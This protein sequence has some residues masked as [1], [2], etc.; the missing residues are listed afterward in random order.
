M[1]K[2]ETYDEF[3]KKFEPKKTTD[4]CYTPAPIMDV[5]NRWAAKEFDLDPAKYIRPF[6]PGGDYQA[7]DYTDRVV[8]DNPPFSILAEIIKWYNERNIKFVLFAPVLTCTQLLRYGLSAYTIKTQIVYENGAQVRTCFLTNI[9]DQNYIVF[10]RELENAIKEVKGNKTKPKLVVPGLLRTIEV[11]TNEIEEPQY[12]AGMK[13]IRKYNG[14]DV[15]GGGFI[16]EE[17]GQDA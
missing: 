3:V 6:Y 13:F 10:S 11:M 12:L 2:N 1:A 14:K 9:P 5:V 7:E 8:V 4:D 16:P 15:F 17:G